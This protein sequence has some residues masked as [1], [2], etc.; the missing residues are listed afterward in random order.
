MP[1]KMVTHTANISPLFVRN[2]TTRC[3]TVTFELFVTPHFNQHHW[4]LYYLLWG[5]IPLLLQIQFN[6]DLKD[7]L[8]K[9]SLS[10]DM[11]CKR[12]HISEFTGV[13]TAVTAISYHVSKEHS[14]FVR[15]HIFRPHRMTSLMSVR[16][17]WCLTCSRLWK[18]VWKNNNV[19]CKTFQTS[20]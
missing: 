10:F 15:N 16:Q 14:T 9:K 6:K 4:E 12:A 8:R 19:L 7:F 17:F 3:K 2:I 13:V 1:A 20:L 18:T 5:A 11:Y